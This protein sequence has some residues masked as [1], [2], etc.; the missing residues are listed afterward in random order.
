MK[1]EKLSLAIISIIFLLIFTTHSVSAQSSYVLPYPSF[2]PGSTFYK[3][4]LIW[5]KISQYWYFGNFGQF[6][7]NL[8]QS[9]KYLVEAKTLFEYS[10]YF[11]GQNALSKS[12]SHFI[13]TLPYL[14]KAKIEH[15]D[16]NKSKNVLKEA[17]L[18]HME[19]LMK[20]EKDIPGVFIWSPE[21]SPST[22]LEL[23]KAI[24]QAI[25]IR[26]NYL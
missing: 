12:N 23:K 14:S 5:E 16:I 24:D 21:K 3:I 8:K 17:A 22:T 19:I 9:D 20:L 15:K 13:N 1:N 18:K 2:M 6:I 10:Q 7:Y 11:L 25:T 26:K 4:H